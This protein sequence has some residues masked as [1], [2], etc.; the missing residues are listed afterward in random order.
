MSLD[1]KYYDINDFNKL[2]INKNSSFATLHLNIASLS[3][4]FDD[5]QNFLSLLKN[6]FNIIGVPE[7]KINKNSMNVDF[8]LNETEGSHRGTGF[9]ISDN[10]TFKQP[11]DLLVNEPGRLESTF[12]ELIFP[13]KTSMI[14]GCICKHRSMKISRFN[15]EYF[16]PLL[17][18][19]QKEE[20][21][22]ML[23]G[24][25]NIN[26][27]NAETNTNISEFYDNTSSHFFAPY[28][29]QPT[30]LTKNSKTLIDNIFQNSIEFETFS[31]NLAFLISDHFPQLLI[32]KDFHRKSTVINNIVYER[33]YRFLP[34]TNLRMI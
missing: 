32:L 13:E 30:R 25:F 33:N 4:H 23:M 17:T 10:L 6:S 2:S 5:L 14:C 1:S 15:G 31:R 19:I 12:I 24:D 26:L 29:L 7:H 9:F 28:I 8:T 11:P 21:T 22:S 27:L 34:I 3:K 18:D 16:T 20:K